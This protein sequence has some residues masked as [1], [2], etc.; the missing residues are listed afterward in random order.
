MN[1]PTSWVPRLLGNC[2]MYI[3]NSLTHVEVI[4]VV[5]SHFDTCKQLSNTSWLGTKYIHSYGM[6]ANCSLS[7]RPKYFYKPT[8]AST[9]HFSPLQATKENIRQFGRRS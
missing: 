7:S 5:R 9:E 2:Y 8:T 6:D 4:T 1:L 3:P